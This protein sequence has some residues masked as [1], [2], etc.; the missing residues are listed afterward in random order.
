MRNGASFQLPSTMNRSLPLVLQVD[1]TTHPTWTG[2]KAGISME[3]ERMQRLMS[4]FG[5]F[6]DTGIPKGE[7]EAAEDSEPTQA[8]PAAASD[9]ASKAS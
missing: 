5:G 7:A 8:E 4:R 3:D 1:T 6:V 9:D 2:E